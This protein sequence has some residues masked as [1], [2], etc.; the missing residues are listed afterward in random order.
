MAK[1]YDSEKFVNDVT[2]YMK[3]HL[4]TYIDNINLEKD[5]GMI[6]NS[7][8]DEAYIFQTLDDKVVNHSPCVFYYID[9][10]VSEGIGPETSEQV[11]LDIVIIMSDPKDGSLAFRLLR[12]LRALKELFNEGFNSLNYSKKI[13]IESLVPVSFALQNSS[14]YVHAIGVRLTTTII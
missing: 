14:D 8:A 6:I 12:Y 1:K 13:N 2:S 3:Q 9:D 4:N 10:I 5:D 7:I 11:M